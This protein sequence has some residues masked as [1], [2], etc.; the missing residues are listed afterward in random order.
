LYL[1]LGVPCSSIRVV[2]ALKASDDD[3]PFTENI[4]SV[5][6]KNHFSLLEKLIVSKTNQKI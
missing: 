4:S 1:V 5:P 3:T 6:K 2:H